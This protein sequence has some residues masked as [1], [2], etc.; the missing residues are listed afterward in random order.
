MLP[1]Y[2]E[3]AEKVFKESDLIKR[4]VRK[5]TW[6]AF[7]EAGNNII[8]DYEDYIKSKINTNCNERV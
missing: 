3:V 6:E 8:S 2:A 5:E 4:H 1:V 7:E